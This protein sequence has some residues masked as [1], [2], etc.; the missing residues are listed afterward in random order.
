MTATV[1]QA[2]FW[3]G[4]G[5]QRWVQHQELLDRTLEP[6]G[7]AALQAARPQRGEAVLDVG[8]GCGWTSLELAQAVAPGGSVLGVDVSAPMLEVARRRAGE[9]GL[10]SAS[11]VVADAATHSPGRRFDLLF[12]RF[13]VMFFDD[14]V[15]AFS[16]LRRAVGP[17]GRLTFVCWGPVA[18]N[19]WFRVP[20]AAAGTVV[21]LPEP[22][23]PD[24][25]GPF[26]FADRGRVQGI[27]ERAGFAEIAVEPS[28]GPFVLGPDVET[29]GT[30]AV[31]TGPV[32]RLLI[33]ADEPTRLRVRDAIRQQLGPF[34]GH[35]GVVL[36]SATWIVR[37]RQTRSG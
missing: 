21:P 24:A 35:G 34:L 6:F 28:S 27:L 11:F 7:R 8:C 16:N 15:A 14:P 18:D 23:P 13:G 32:S 22:T 2:E 36:P 31:E 9:R 33:D 29:A 25:P 19:P 3:N 26:S 1:D 20:M 4:P 37:A 17:G 30:N 10:D 12:S 5:A